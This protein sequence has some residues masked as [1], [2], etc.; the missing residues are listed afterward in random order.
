MEDNLVLLYIDR[1]DGPIYVTEEEYDRILSS[2]N[3][4]FN[5]EVDS[6]P[7]PF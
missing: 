3:W 7:L 6:D 5:E 4:L 2:K 1:E